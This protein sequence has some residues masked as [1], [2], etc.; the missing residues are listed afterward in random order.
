[1]T[2]KSTVKTALPKDLSPETLIAA[3]HNHELY[4]KLSDPDVI[5]TVLKS[6]DPSK[7]GEACV[8]TVTSK[9]HTAD[10]QVTSQA[11]GLDT[12]AAVKSPVGTLNITTKW[13]VADGTLKE[14]IEIE[15]NFVM[16]KMAKGPT[17]KNAEETHRKFLVEVA[18]A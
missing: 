3:L 5:S 2:T 12:K 8:Y 6:G 18:K 9:A 4:F 14:D 11:D 10:Y 13:R 1:M 17:E 7:I 15:A 16:R